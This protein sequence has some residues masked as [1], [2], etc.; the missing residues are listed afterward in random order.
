MVRRFGL[1]SSPIPLSYYS[2][3]HHVDP[4]K[5]SCSAMLVTGLARHKC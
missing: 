3:N 1:A 4:A 5:R 2:T